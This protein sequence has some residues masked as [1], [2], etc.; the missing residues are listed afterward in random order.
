MFYIRTADRLQRTSAWIEALE[1][2]LAY[3]REVIVE[4]S[5]GLCAELDAAMARHVDSY[6]DEWRDTLADPERL[7]RFTSFVNAP[8]VPDP[9]ITFQTVRGQPVPAATGTAPDPAAA[10]PRPDPAAAEP[11]V[12]AAAVGV[13]RPVPLGLPQPRL[14]EVPR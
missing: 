3:L 10:G 6:S 9:S 12:G 13:R 4:D 11:G 2:G 5:L 7:A 8:G 14:P 1:G